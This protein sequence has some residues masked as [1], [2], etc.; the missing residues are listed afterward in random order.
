MKLVDLGVIRSGITRDFSIKQEVLYADFVWENLLELAQNNT[1]T[2]SLPPK[3]PEVKRALALM[4]DQETSFLEIYQLAKQTEPK[5]LKSIDLFD[6]YQGKN[7][8]EGK[9]SYA[10]SFILQNKDKTLEEKQIE[11]IMLKLQK[12]FEAKLGASLR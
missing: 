6:V 1:I 3:F 5:F 11:G 10:V 2:V 7:L 4:I 8:P 12:A 9:K